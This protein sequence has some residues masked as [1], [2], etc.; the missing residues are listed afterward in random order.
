MNG[1]A[2]ALWRLL[3]RHPGWSNTWKSR[4]E[5]QAIYSLAWARR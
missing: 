5:Q 3:V 4:C 1:A 2:L